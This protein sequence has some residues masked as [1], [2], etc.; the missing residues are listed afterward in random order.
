MRIALL[1]TYPHGGA[2]IACGRLA[3]A[4]RRV[5]VDARVLTGAD[6]SS[7]WPFYAE[8]L[9]F[10]PYE[11]DRSVRF[12]FSLANVGCDMSRHPVVQAADV[13]HLHW[14]NQG[15]LSLKGI[16]RLARLG[17]PVVWTLHD[18]WAF[19]GGC[20]YSADCKR[21]QDACSY[22]PMVR[23]PGPRDLS[24]R[25]WR[26]KK[27]LF[28]PHL[29]II[30]CSEWLGQ[31]ARSSSLLRDHTI[32]V[33]PNAI[34]TE[35]FAPISDAQRQL[36]RQ[37]WGIP[38][39]AVLALFSSVKVENPWKGFSHLVDALKHLIRHRPDV[40]IVLMV[41]G[42]A[43]ADTLQSLPCPVYALGALSEPTQL[44]AAYA[45]ADVFII[46]S[47]EENLPNTVM[48]ALS[49]G[50]P[51]AGF[52]AGGISEMVDHGRNGYLAPVG[53][54]RAL[55]DAILWVA[56]RSPQLRLAARQKAEQCYRLEVVGQR[57]LALYR[58]L[59]ERQEIER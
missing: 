30:T 24:H 20:H 45:S 34:D 3:A 56:E 50:T 17:K 55:A 5:G 32:E 14:I 25:I 12:Q 35:L 8:R 23:W 57:H 19:T 18:M 40:P 51:V 27:R 33:V 44:A 46:P 6:A 9:S 1:T 37:Q 13:I 31:C 42:K 49:C 10:L 29:T 52:S 47:L 54:T 41:M 21:Y 16:A 15:F 4:L 22:C 48:E 39:N 38:P 28:P 59:L 43:H 53:D 7:R 2:G 11:R 36:F 58:R 26:R